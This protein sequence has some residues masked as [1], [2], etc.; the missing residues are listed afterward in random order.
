MSASRFS[1]MRVELNKI[2]IRDVIIALVAIGAALGFTVSSPA[3]V[4]VELKAAD[5]AIGARVTTNEKAIATLGEQQRFNSYLLC[6][7]IRRSDPTATPPDCEP[8]KTRVAV[9]LE[10]ASLRKLRQVF[11]RKTDLVVTGEGEIIRPN[12]GETISRPIDAVKPPEQKP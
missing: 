12:F 5:V 8:E 3:K 6:M 11:T 7:L 10:I 9:M 1:A 4:V 2:S